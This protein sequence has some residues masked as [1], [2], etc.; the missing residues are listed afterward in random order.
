MS[1]WVKEYPS[2]AARL[3]AYVEQAKCNADSPWTTGCRECPLKMVHKHTVD[4]GMDA[5]KEWLK[6]EAEPS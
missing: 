3:L 5:A 4:C 2:P 6:M 1:E